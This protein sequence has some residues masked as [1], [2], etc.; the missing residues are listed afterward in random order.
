MF[1]LGNLAVVFAL[2]GYLN[3]YFLYPASI[4]FQEVTMPRLEERYR[5]F[6]VWV[7][8]GTRPRF[9]FL[10]TIGLLIFSFVLL[11]VIPPKTLFFPINQ[12]QYVNVFIEKP[13]G[14]DIKETD[15]TTRLVEER[16][17][18]LL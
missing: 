10:G 17:F 8:A 2:F 18:K 14:T 6:L 1:T 15:A 5:L 16:V 11:G 4:R 7:L 3:H 12:P 9:M 13:I